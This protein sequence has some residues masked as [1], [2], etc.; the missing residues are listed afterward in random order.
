MSDDRLAPP[1][2]TPDEENPEQLRADI[3]RTR[4][5]MS[6]TIGAIQDKLR[7]E[8]LK[9]QAVAQ[10]NEVKEKLKEELREQVDELRDKVKEEIRDAKDKLREATVGKVEHM[11]HNATDTVEQAGT[12]V[13]ET[14]RANPIPAALVG[15]GIAWLLVNRRNARALPR[16]DYRDV[17]RRHQLDDRVTDRRAGRGE[18]LYAD[19]IASADYDPRYGRDDMQVRDERGTIGRIQDRV[20]DV[21]QR[22]QGAVGGAVHQVGDAAHQVGDRTKD[23]AH[24]VSDRTK[25]LAHQVSDRT[26]DVAHQVSDRTRDVAHQ[27][28]DRAKDAAHRAQDAAGELADRAKDAAS[29]AQHAASDLAVRARGTADELAGRARYGVRQAESRVQNTYETNPLA[30]GA[31][32]LIAGVAVGLSLPRTRREDQLMGQARDKLIHRAQ[33][34]AHE[35]MEKV[36]GVVSDKL[37][38]GTSQNGVAKGYGS[39]PSA[40]SVLTARATRAAAAPGGRGDP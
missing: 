10:L 23:L 13:F 1:A 35:T 6:E 24:Q 20:G 4:A 18:H 25:D 12:S 31:I 39:H 32:A 33:E 5:Q 34:A 26:R 38:N 8:D 15:I 11:V 40:N 37:Q 27:V 17:E 21:A 7:P 30:L 22:V 3:E 36:Q 29:R 14:V 19:E 28:G 2:A 9:N 16:A